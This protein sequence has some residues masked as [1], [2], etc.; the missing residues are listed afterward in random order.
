MLILPHATALTVHRDA[1][2]LAAAV[3][4]RIAALI[5]QAIAARGMCRLALAGGETPRRCYTELG[6]L[7]V[8]WTRVQIYFGDERC[9]PVGDA[10]RNDEMAR[11]SL[12]Q[13][14]GIPAANVHAVAAEL[15]AVQAAADYAARLKDVLPL[16]IVLLGMG[17][18]GHSAS[19]FPGNPALRAEGVAVAVFDAPKPPPERVSLSLTTLNSARHKLFL[20]AGAGKQAALA[21]I[22]RGEALPA[23]QIIDAEWHLEQNAVPAE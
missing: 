6:A 3:A 19:L 8:D 12:L 9:L 15:G 11:Q 5:G 18:D 2:A 20:I 17:E 10:Q 7:A 16:D 21:R 4:Q 1:E 23:A 13:P 22:A 14:A